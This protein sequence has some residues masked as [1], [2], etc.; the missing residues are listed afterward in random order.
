MTREVQDALAARRK[1]C[2]LKNAQGL[3]S[4]QSACLDFGVARSSFY[5]WK[6]AYAEGGWEGLVRKK[7]IAKSHPRQIPSEF[8]E[9]ILHLRSVYHLGPQRIAW[10]LERYHGFKTPCSS[11]YRTLKRNGIGPLPGKVRSRAI[12]TRRY[13]KQVPGHQIQVEESYQLLAYADDVDLNSKLAAW[14]KFYNLNRP[15]GAHNSK[16][17]Y[18]VLRSMLE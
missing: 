7:P 11:V 12:H 1:L 15:H 8:V 3:G 4:V 6:K 16:S 18:E 10:Y 13:A 5:C 9:K 2:I 17:P 14:E